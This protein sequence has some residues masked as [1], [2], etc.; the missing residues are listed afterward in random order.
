MLPKTTDRFEE[1]VLMLYSANPEAWRELEKGLM[2]LAANYASSAVT[3]TSN[4][5]FQQQLL[6][7]FD[8]CMDLAKYRQRLEDSK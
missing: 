3:S 4:V 5:N 2:E 6:G 8:N 1:A 7:K